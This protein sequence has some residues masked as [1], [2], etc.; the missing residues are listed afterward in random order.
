MVEIPLR[1]SPEEMRRLGYKAVDE[2]V[3]HLT[4]LREQPVGR[5]PDRERLESL[6]DADPPTA[7]SDAVEVMTRTVELVRDSI[8]HPDHP[9][10]LAYVPG[11]ST[12]VG[13]VA[14]FLASGL[15]VFAG[16]WLVGP[17]PAVMERITIDWLRRM[18]GLPDTAGGLFVS[19]GTMA[20]LVAIHAARSRRGDP[21]N[22]GLQ[23]VYTS[24]QTHSSIRRGLHFLGFSREQ[25]RVVGTDDRDRM[26]VGAL[27]E[28]IVQDRAAGL[29]PCCVVATAGTTNTGAVDPLG[30]LAELCA[31]QGVWLHVDGA[32]GAAAVLSDRA[33]GLLTG[34]EHAD[35]ITLDPHKW[36]YQPYE[37]G[38]VLVRDESTLVDAFS[39]NA[40]YLRE[41]RYASAPLNYYDMGPQLTRGFRA[42]KLWMSIKTFG[43]D[44]F[45]QAV[46]H[47]IALAEHAQHILQDSDRWEVV[48]PAQLAIVTFRPRVPG[49]PPC[50]V[51]ALTRRIAAATLDDGFALVMT[52]E[53][54]ERP[55]LRLCVTHPETT[56]DDIEQTVAVL[57]RLAREEA[58]A[59]SSRFTTGGNLQA[60]PPRFG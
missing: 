60:S 16:Q 8:A 9:R 15:N 1:L 47:G 10:F 36:W 24:S 18:C 44:A 59:E 37:A 25:L 13:A 32:Y 57:E 29:R 7:P 39:M 43:L 14:D 11:P 6:F 55:V 22:D 20:S 35:S 56:R 5:T 2:I 3:D 53:V 17:G 40:E 34:I 4:T 51:D 38:C 41:T 45:R 49:A 12:Y 31:S 30:P 54:S 50:D 42:L 58:R 52:T 27:A 23:V 19:G 33:G 48:T 21:G 26:D 46:D 28:R